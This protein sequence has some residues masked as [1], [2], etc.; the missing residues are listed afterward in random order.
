MLLRTP[1]RASAKDLPALRLMRMSSDHRLPLLFFFR[2]W[3][4]RLS[5]PRLCCCCCWIFP[6]FNATWSFELPPRGI[7]FAA[8]L[9]ATLLFLGLLLSIV[10]SFS[11][12]WRHGVLWNYGLCF[13]H[14]FSPVF[15]EF[16]WC[17]VRSRSFFISITPFSISIEMFPWPMA[18]AFIFRRISLPVA[19]L[20]FGR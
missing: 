9:A 19:S 12:G 3:W 18:A 8:Y 6:I 4:Y 7:I 2:A 20:L 16:L 11:G 13:P 5:W 10:R 14:S 17:V 15:Q 1:R